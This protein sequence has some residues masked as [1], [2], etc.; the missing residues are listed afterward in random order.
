VFLGIDRD[1]SGNRGR[2]SGMRISS[3]NSMFKVVE[4]AGEL[5]GMSGPENRMEEIKKECSAE[6]QDALLVL[7]QSEESRVLTE[8]AYW[9]VGME[10]VQEQKMKVS[11]W[12]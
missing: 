4:F 10:E 2:E 3:I 7:K 11:R 1:Y 5:D 6:Y 9:H 8:E 12:I